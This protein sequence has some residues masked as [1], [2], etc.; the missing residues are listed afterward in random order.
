M[1]HFTKTGSGQTWGKL[2]KKSGVSLGGGQADWDDHTDISRLCL[3]ADGT[4]KTVDDVFRDFDRDRSGQ[5]DFDEYL[6]AM[7]RLRVEPTLA[8]ELF[9]AADL[10][11][12]E[13]DMEEFQAL[14]VE[15][16]NV[17]FGTSE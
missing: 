12:G 3:D 14:W 13:L 8:R 1:H 11:D 2:K 5:M 7:S 17:L 4:L 9:E 10:P 15:M 6:A 16:R